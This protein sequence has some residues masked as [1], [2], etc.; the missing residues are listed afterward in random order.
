MGGSQVRV[1]ISQ[2]L[3]ENSTCLLSLLSDYSI[4]NNQLSQ[5]LVLKQLGPK[6]RGQQGVSLRLGLLILLVK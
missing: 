2:V 6:E 4:L 3:E 1:W 5:G